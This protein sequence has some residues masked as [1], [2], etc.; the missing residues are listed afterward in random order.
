MI[1]NL[2]VHKV[3]RDLSEA[4]VEKLRNFCDKV[5]LTTGDTIITEGEE[6]Y[7]FFVI[8]SGSLAVF[9]KS[10]NGEDYRLGTKKE[11]EI[12]GELAFIQP[13]VRSATIKAEGP[14]ELIKVDGGR[15]RSDPQYIDLYAALSVEMGRLVSANLRFT[16]DVTVKSMEAEL[17][18]AKLLL[19]AG[20]FMVTVVFLV[21]MY[22]FSLGAI[23]LLEKH[24][25]STTPISVVLIFLFSAAFLVT[26]LRS[27][28]PL[29]EY[30]LTL[31]NWGRVSVEA[32]LF[33]IPILLLIVL[34][35]WIV[36]STVP[37]LSGESTFQ[38]FYQLQKSG[39]PLIDFLVFPLTY[40]V[41]CPIQEFIARG[42]LQSSFQLFLTKKNWQSVW[43]SNILGNLLF[44]ATHVHTSF[45]FAMLAFLP[46]IF[47]GWMYSRQQ[48]LIGVSISHILIGFWALF[49][50]SFEHLV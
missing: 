7:D 20:R 1:E 29:E 32:V 15:I 3:F 21:S 9:K 36:I 44:S 26:I 24:L 13:G 14:C 28:F 16:N 45:G 42:V 18:S 6:C 4:Q 25:T 17:N 30:G 40:V 38:P 41:F 12:I 50:I 31:K 35:K 19:G 10:K 23:S 22:I 49:I 11:G 43:I 8:L 27:G 2:L 5:T 39:A 33:S 46:G 47:W 48:S 34:I 37:E